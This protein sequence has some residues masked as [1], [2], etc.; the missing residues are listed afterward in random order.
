LLSAARATVAIYTEPVPKVFAVWCRRSHD[1]ERQHRHRRR[2]RVAL[3]CGGVRRG[4]TVGS[5]HFDVGVERPGRLVAIVGAFG[6]Q[7]VEDSP[8]LSRMLRGGAAG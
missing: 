3:K 1:I 8:E 7:S 5:Q 6:E 2:V 4:A